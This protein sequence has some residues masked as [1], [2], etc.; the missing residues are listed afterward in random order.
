MAFALGTTALWIIA[1]VLPVEG[2]DWL[3]AATIWTGIVRL[4]WGS[5]WGPVAGVACASAILPVVA[6]R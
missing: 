1:G 5:P 2:M 6:P 4:V 3:R